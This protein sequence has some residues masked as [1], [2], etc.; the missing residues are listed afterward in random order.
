MSVDKED[1]FDEMLGRAL[2]RSPEPVPADFTNRILRQ[3]EKA[4]EQRILAQV[5]LQERLAL[6]GCIALGITTIVAAVV[7]PGIATSFTKQMGGFIG[8]IPQ[9]IEVVSNEWQLYLRQS[10]MTVFAGVFGFAVYT[11]LDSLVGDS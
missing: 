2:R 3:I 4:E 11:L 5:V 1:K 7:F 8:K 10:Y 6:A 9:A